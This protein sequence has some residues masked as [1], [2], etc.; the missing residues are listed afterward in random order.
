MAPKV[1]GFVELLRRNVRSMRRLA[2]AMPA[3]HVGDTGFRRAASRAYIQRAYLHPHG[4]QHFSAGL[5]P[6]KKGLML[7]TFTR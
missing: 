1:E 3:T 5:W 2:R 7:K 6:K 4:A